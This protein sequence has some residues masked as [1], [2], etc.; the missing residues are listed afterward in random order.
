METSFSL[1]PKS[2]SAQISL[3]LYVLQRKIKTLKLLNLPF[4]RY[5]RINKKQLGWLQ[6][7]NVK[8]CAKATALMIIKLPS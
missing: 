7:L 5:I 3:L 4:G 6:F 1:A 2:N 8:S